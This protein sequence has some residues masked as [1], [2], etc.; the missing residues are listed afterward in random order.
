LAK[1]KDSILNRWFLLVVGTYPPETARFLTSQ[2]NEF[3]NPVRSNLLKGLEGLY[4]GLMENKS[5]SAD[6]SEFLDQIIRIRAV[7]DLA[8]SEALVFVFFLKNAVRE[9]L[10][11]HVEEFRLFEELLTFESRVDRL[12]LLAFNIYVQCRE[13]L[14]DVKLAEIRRRTSR[15]LERASQKYGTAE[16]W[17]GPDD[18]EIAK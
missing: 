1:E 13:S 4:T 2:K 12:A 6:F 8:P 11:S 18:D 16:D 5:D 9:K 10:A 7:Q 3:S 17:L 15:I 14:Y